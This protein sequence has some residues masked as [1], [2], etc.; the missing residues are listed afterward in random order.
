MV[1]RH[2]PVPL[3]APAHPAKKDPLL[4]TAVSVTGVPEPK[5]AVQVGAQL[6]PAGLLLALPLPA[7]ANWTDSWNEV[8]SD[9]A[10][11][12]P[13]AE[14]EAGDAWASPRAEPFRIHP[15]LKH[16]ASESKLHRVNN[17]PPQKWT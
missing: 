12:E 1:S 14:S 2:E 11:W 9:E 4:A 8:A 5:T 15:A 3:Q 16:A 13:K 6:I 7:P 10:T 17:R